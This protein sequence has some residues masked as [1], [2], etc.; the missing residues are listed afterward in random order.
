M[1]YIIKS[2][3][4]SGDDNPHP[5]DGHPVYEENY[6][7]FVDKHWKEHDPKFHEMM[8][9]HRKASG[10]DENTTKED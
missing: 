4:K 9:R 2:E 3:K 1:K 6:L 10:T 5:L 8:M 7:K